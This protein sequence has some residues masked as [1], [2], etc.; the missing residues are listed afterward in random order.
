LLCQGFD[1]F[2]PF[3]QRPIIDGGDNLSEGLHPRLDI[4]FICRIGNGQ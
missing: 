2:F 3:G 4:R 1:E